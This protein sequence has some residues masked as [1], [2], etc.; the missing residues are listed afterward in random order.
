[1]IHDWKGQDDPVDPVDHREDWRIWIDEDGGDIHRKRL[2]LSLSLR[3]R[4]ESILVLQSRG[5]VF[6]ITTI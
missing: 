4:V 5:N 3:G 2:F 6:L 1:M